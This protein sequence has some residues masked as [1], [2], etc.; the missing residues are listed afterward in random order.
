MK[1]QIKDN[2]IPSALSALKCERCGQA[3]DPKKAK[4]LELSNTDGNYYET[5]PK[6]HISQGGFSFGTDC[7]TT[8]LKETI[9]A[10]SALSINGDEKENWLLSKSGVDVINDK[11]EYIALCSSGKL[12]PTKKDLIKSEANAALIA[13]APDMYKA[14]KE[15]VED[16]KKTK[17][18]YNP[19]HL[20]MCKSI[21]QKANPK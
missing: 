15:Y 3:I 16:C 6:G 10:I 17:W 20:K 18:G 21:L 19:E 4:W 13:A 5:T 12:Y 14:I 9:A 1:Q 7:A 2:S 8:Q 11:G